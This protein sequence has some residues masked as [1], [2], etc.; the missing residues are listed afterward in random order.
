MLECPNVSNTID[1]VLL[2]VCSVEYFV[3]KLQVAGPLTDCRSST[4]QEITTS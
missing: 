2:T 1:D 3:R 4:Y